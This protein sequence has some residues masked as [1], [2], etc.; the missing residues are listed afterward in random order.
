MEIIKDINQGT[1]EWNALRIGSLGGSSISKATAVSKE[2]KQRTQLL[3]D[4]AGEIIS[5]K[6]KEH[7]VNQNMLNGTEWENEARLYYSLMT[8]NEVETIAMI[9]DGPHK[10]VSP[11]GLVDENGMIEIKNVIPSTF[12]AYI[13]KPSIPTAYKKQMQ[14]SFARSQRR[15]CDYVLYCRDFVGQSNPMVV[16]RV[17]RNEKEIGELEAGADLF[18]KDLLALVERVKGR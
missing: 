18:I 4:M 10:H 16:T 15:W 17:V 2:A 6:K 3:Y 8:G 14:W 1:P 5:G 12:V 13:D 11:D 9:K 7:Y